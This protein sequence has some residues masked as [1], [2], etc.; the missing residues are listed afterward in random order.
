M[1]KKRF[2]KHKDIMD[3]VIGLFQE[4]NN[5]SILCDYEDACVLRDIMSDTYFKEEYIEMNNTK[6][7]YIVSRIGNDGF[8]IEPIIREDKM[9]YGEDN[10]LVVM[11]Y[12]IYEH[13]D[14]LDYFDGDEVIVVGLENQEGECE[15]CCNTENAF[16]GMISDLI[17]N[18]M[19][20]TMEELDEVRPCED[21][22]R[23]IL[24]GLLTK[25][26]DIGLSGILEKK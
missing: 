3:Y 8:Y 11:E 13:E 9:I 15:E 12:L 26:I 16:Y 14:I 21:C 25:G 5:I 6:D 7:E 24:L 1:I 20:D 23:E 18:T 4:K 10:C 2:Q 19:E 17:E 22:T